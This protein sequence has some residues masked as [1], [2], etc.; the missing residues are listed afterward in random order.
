MIVAG[1][2][3]GDGNEGS[4]KDSCDADSEHPEQSSCG[5]AHSRSSLAS[6]WQP[7]GLSCCGC[8]RLH[9]AC[10]AGGDWARNRPHAAS[11]SAT[12]FLVAACICRVAA[13]TRGAA[14]VDSIA[15]AAL[16]K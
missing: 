2:L 6:P 13:A 7:G 8:C 1:L 14:A 15:I 11:C 9:L 4:G 10:G 12:S 16:H 5:K 3:G